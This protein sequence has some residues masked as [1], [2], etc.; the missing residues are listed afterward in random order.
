M[1]R[2]FWSLYGQ[3]A[4]DEVKAPHKERT[5]EHI[6]KTLADRAGGKLLDA[7]CGTG[8]YALA[9]AQSG[10]DVTAIDYADG[11]LARAKSKVTAEDKI[12]FQQMDLNQRLLFDTA[13]FD[14]V[15]SISVLFAVADP[16]FT[17]N[18]MWRVLKPGGV[19]LLTHVPKHRAPLHQII[20]QRLSYLYPKTPDRIALVIVKAL[21]ERAPT[22][23]YWVIEDLIGMFLASKFQVSSVGHGPPIVIYAMKPENHI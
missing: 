19:C 7:G 9:F 1:Q 12:T 15:I 3:L 11:M 22:A 2:A 5:L 17:L 4:W 20:Q 23:Q 21:Q 8:N 10:F 18:E 16:V 6:L 14:C 13:V